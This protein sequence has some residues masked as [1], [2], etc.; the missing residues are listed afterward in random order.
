MYFKYVGDPD[1]DFF[2]DYINEDFHKFLNWFK[3]Q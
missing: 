2:I 3:P 1:W